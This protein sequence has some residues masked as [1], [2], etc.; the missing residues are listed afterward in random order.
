MFAEIIDKP[1]NFSQQDSLYLYRRI[2]RYGML[3]RLKEFYHEYKPY[4]RIDL[5]MY[6][7]LIL[8]IIGYLIVST[9]L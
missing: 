2:N 8:L 3:K 5:I 6:A 1:A 7:V 4:V 9:L